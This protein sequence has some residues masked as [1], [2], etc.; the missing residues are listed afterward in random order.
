MEWPNLAWSQLQTYS[1]FDRPSKVRIED[2]GRPVRSA[3]SFEDWLASLPQQL[4]A[5]ELRR[6]R[7]AIVTAVRRGRGVVAALGGHVI[8]TGCGPYLIDWVQRGVLRAVAMNGSAAIHDFELA[9]AGKTSEDV[10]AQLP[11]GRFG[12]ARETAEIF[13]LAAERAM[14]ENIG[15]GA[16]LGAC[17]LERNLP[18]VE[19]SLVASAYRA[20]CPCTIHVALGTDIIHMHPQVRGAT[21]GEASMNDFRLLCRVVATLEQG[22]WMNLGSAVIMPEVFLK[23]V[24]VVRN[25]GYSLEGLLTVNFDKHVQYRSRVNVCERP[26]AASIEI[27]GHHEILIPLLHAAVASALDSTQMQGDALSSSLAA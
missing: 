20:G 22:I 18:Y 2:L 27:I 8:K 17:M 26:A 9:C 12:M 7:D 14:Q 10:A 19:S 21:L 3:V 23:A 1:L 6:L 4:A 11:A 5:V 24:S 25:L 16:A 13:A 15:L